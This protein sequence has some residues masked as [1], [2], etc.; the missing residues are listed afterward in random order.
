[1][2]EDF[3]A[4]FKRIEP[5]R[6]SF[7]RTLLR[8]HLYTS[9]KVPPDVD[10]TVDFGPRGRHWVYD[11]TAVGQGVHEPGLIK[12]LIAL[13]RLMGPLDGRAFYDVGSLY[14]YVAIM[15]AAILR[16]A[17]TLAFEM[18]PDSASVVADNAALNPDLKVEVVPAGLTSEHTANVRCMYKDF[19]LRIRPDMDEAARLK[20]NGFRE[21]MLD[22]KTLD[23]VA[24][25]R[26]AAPGVIKIDVE[27]SQ[28]SIIRGGGRI[29][30]ASKPVLLIES[31]LPHAANRD[32]SSM[33]DLCRFLAE[34]YGYR[35]VFFDHRKWDS[36]PRLLKPR[37]KLPE[38]LE[39]NQ[40]IVALPR[41]SAA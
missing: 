9:F 28:M 25:D 2:I 35:M 36:E 13:R 37:K 27:G 29:L 30:K 32:G 33:G 23:D 21:A 22:L 41:K 24:A 5:F 34:E 1:M 17:E 3:V 38:R 12:S 18:N 20:Q 14:G 8:K 4:E 26:K 40:L 10:V 7:R 6:T 16:P 11:R 39:R 15:G 19:T 31:D